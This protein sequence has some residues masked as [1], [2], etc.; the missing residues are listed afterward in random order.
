MG[1]M[2]GSAPGSPPGSAQ[3]GVAGKAGGAWLALRAAGAGLLFATGGIHLDLYLTGYRTIP[4]IGWLFLFQ[5]I[6]S[7]GLGAL[8]LAVPGSIRIGGLALSGLACAAGAL[9]AIGTLAG[10][11]VTLQFGMFGFKEIRT[12]AGLVAGVVEVAAFA[13]LSACALEAARPRLPAL[14]QG[15]AGALSVGALSV[16]G[17]AL[18]GIALAAASPAGAGSGLA[19]GPGVTASG[20]PGLRTAVI[21][22]TRVLTNAAGRTLYWFGRDTSTRS[23]CTGSCAVYWPPVA[24]PLR[25]A[26]GVPGRLGTISRPDGGLQETYDG[27]PLYTY[28]GD[29][30]PGQAHGNNLN[31]N[32]GVWHEVVVAP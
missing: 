20:G 27:H 1:S 13:V 31:L 9:L 14:A 7:L 22:G 3:D 8:V 15:T 5:V 4:A 2:R 12:T 29:S 18:L 11:L 17:L 19:S 6:A 25:A 26:S 30:G 16:A 10:Y 28:A 24:G 21:G 32:G 23:A